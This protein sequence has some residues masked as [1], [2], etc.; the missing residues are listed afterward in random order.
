MFLNKVSMEMIGGCYMHDNIQLSYS[1]S[2]R[3]ASEAS[4]NACKLY[5]GFSTST[6]PIPRVKLVDT[7]LV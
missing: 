7:N 5:E 3:T 4:R 2:S 6:N 1:D